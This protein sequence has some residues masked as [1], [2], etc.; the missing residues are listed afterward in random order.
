MVKFQELKEELQSVFSG[1]GIKLVD[2]L[3]PLVLFLVIN[4]TFSLTAAVG[5]ALAA[6]G[7]FL[8]LR[9]VQQ[10]SLI[11]ALL[12]AGGAALAA[13]WVYL[14]G[15][16]SSFFLPGLISGVITVVI[17]AGS[18][19]IAKPVAAVTSFITR[20]WP[21]DWYW[22]DRVRPA[23]SEVSWFWGVAFGA[24][25]ALEYWLLQQDAVTALGAVRIFLGWPYTIFILVVSYLYGTWRLGKLDGPSVDEF[26]AGDEPPWKGQQ[27]GF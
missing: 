11:Y 3:L 24:R 16:E 2:T 7:G 5:G 15:N 17:C 20:R 12:G 4:Q 14:S 13:G 6:A 25:T 9:L 1:R 19:I 27:R 22:H 26:K 21:L 23:Y 8:A 10:E 18:A